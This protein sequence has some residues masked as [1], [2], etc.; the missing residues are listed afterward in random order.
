MRI[1]KIGL[2]IIILSVLS[3]SAHAATI[4]KSGCY[5]AN[6]GYP[7]ILLKPSP[8][9]I[10]KPAVVWFNGRPIVMKRIIDAQQNIVSAFG[11]GE[12]LD[13]IDFS[14]GFSADSKKYKIPIKGKCRLLAAQPSDAVGC[15]DYRYTPQGDIIYKCGFNVQKAD[16]SVS[17]G[18][19]PI[20]YGYYFYGMNAFVMESWYNNEN[21]A[22]FFYPTGVKSSLPIIVLMHGMH[23]S[24]YQNKFLPNFLGYKYLGEALASKGFFV[25]SI[26]A[27]AINTN[28]SYQPTAMKARASLINLQLQYLQN[29]LQSILQGKSLALDFKNI[30]I[31]G[32]SRAGEGVVYAYNKLNGTYGIKA[33]FSLAPTNDFKQYT[34]G[35]TRGI[36]LGYCDGDVDSLDGVYY[37]DNA[38]PGQKKNTA[39]KYFSILMGANHN[40]FNTVWSDPAWGGLDDWIN[41]SS[42]AQSTLVDDSHCGTGKS[43]RLTKMQQQ[44]AAVSYIVPFFQ[45]HLQNKVIKPASPASKAQHN[46]YQPATTDRLLINT[47]QTT[48]NL[49]DLGGAVTVKGNINTN[50]SCGNW[51]ADKSQPIQCV[52][53][54]TKSATLGNPPEN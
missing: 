3:I 32:H 42:F 21:L 22:Q 13:S 35:V 45:K 7:L 27:N 20:T 29:N 36:M 11:A 34:T 19:Y 28:D 8:S 49:N 5:V 16:V 41:D 24:Q 46:W 25:I 17:G 30:A 26:S 39:G 40:Y 6:A 14:Y 1:I 54:N 31:L 4:P 12:G 37:F 48:N 18:K 33:V 53:I 50:P 44:A 10:S 38:M 47:F 52:T 9:M 43:T 2:Q 51:L 15:T 23:E